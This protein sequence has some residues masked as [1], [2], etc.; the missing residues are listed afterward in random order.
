MLS[1]PNTISIGADF[2]DVLAGNFVG[3]IAP[4]LNSTLTCKKED[5]IKMEGEFVD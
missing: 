2:V 1:P 3:G 4:R 5:E